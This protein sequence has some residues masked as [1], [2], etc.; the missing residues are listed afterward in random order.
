[1]DWHSTIVQLSSSRL[2]AGASNSGFQQFLGERSTHI[3]STDGPSLAHLSAPKIRSLIGDLLLHRSPRSVPSD[4]LTPHL[5]DSRCI[6][7]IE[8]S[9]R[10]RAAEFE[11]NCKRT[12]TTK[13]KYMPNSNLFPRLRTYFTYL[14]YVHVPS[15]TST[16]AADHPIIA[17]LFCADLWTERREL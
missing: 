6:D 5:T 8:A 12:R 11:G 14:R 13:Y 17:H 15:T 16:P 4:R 9:A 3:I 1:M 7:L 10:S 2:R